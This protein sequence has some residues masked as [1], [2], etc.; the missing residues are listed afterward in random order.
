MA[1]KRLPP[2][3]RPGPEDAEKSERP[4]DPSGPTMSDP[5]VR[6]SENAGPSEDATADIE[7]RLARGNKPN[8]AGRAPADSPPS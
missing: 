6:P 1:E 7:E 3:G 8:P 5:G 2:R 4:A